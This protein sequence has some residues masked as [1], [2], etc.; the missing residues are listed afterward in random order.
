[1]KPEKISSGRKA[2]FY[3]GFALTVVGLALFIGGAFT[4]F[5]SFG[6]FDKAAAAMKWSGVLSFSGI[7]VM[8]LGAIVRRAGARGL[9]GSGIVL[10]PEQ[11]R[12]DLQPYSQMAGG[13]VSD[14]VGAYRD[15][16]AP[17]SAP[18]KVR[19]L[20]CRNLNDETA[21]FCSKCGAQIG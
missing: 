10:D 11:A 19:C 5:T 3:W 9:A 17:E 2:A 7:I 6:E 21:Q 1:M 13:M 12:K 14:A 4:M 15:S 18:I 16:S 20:K 8:W